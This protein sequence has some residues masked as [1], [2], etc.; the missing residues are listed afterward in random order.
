MPD[1]ELNKIAYDFF[2]VFSRMEYAL[3]VSGFNN[4]D[5]VAKANWYKF[6]T[7][8]DIENFIANPPTTEISEAID[9]IIGN[10]PMRQS[11]KNNILGWE[12]VVPDT[13]SNADKLF[14]YIRRV[15][16]NLFHGGKFNGNWFEPQRSES[17]IKN[18]LIILHAVIKCEPTINDAYNDDDGKFTGE[19]IP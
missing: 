12:T 17:L 16:N 19:L 10:P 13:K 18:S 14:Q 5:G 3:K 11:V 15:R 9:Y 7:H 8:Q 6:A 2:L 1:N 4:G